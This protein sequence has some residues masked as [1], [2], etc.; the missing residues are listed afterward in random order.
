MTAVTR[1]AFVLWCLD[2]LERRVPYLWGGKGAGALD[3]SGFVTFPLFVLSHGA[4]DMRATHNTDRLWCEFPRVTRPEP[5]DVALY[6]G[7]G[8]TGPDDVEHAMVYVGANAVVGQAIGGRANISREWSQSR[9]H[10]T[11]AR[12]LHYR[13]DLAGFV[14]LPLVA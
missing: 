1:D 7:K 10:W 8:S 11:K 2:A 3:C 4:V 13:N 12:A 6:F 9:G 5:G 14:R